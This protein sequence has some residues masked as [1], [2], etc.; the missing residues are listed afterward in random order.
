MTSTVVTTTLENY[1]PTIDL[2]SIPLRQA[3]G[4]VEL[5]QSI[6]TIL[7]AAIKDDLPPEVATYLDNWQ[8][9]FNEQAF[10]FA[11]IVVDMEPT[12]EFER[13]ARNWLLLR[14][15]LSC[16]EGLMDLTGSGALEYDDAFSRELIAKG[17]A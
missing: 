4:L 8:A 13:R 15:R 2:A 16:A 14:V 5:L 12:E 9:L 1:C 11:D 6:S 17:G 3:L 7:N 10:R